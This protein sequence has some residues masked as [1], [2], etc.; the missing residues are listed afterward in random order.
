MKTVY[1][2]PS[3]QVRKIRTRLIRC[4]RELDTVI[5]RANFETIPGSDGKPYVLKPCPELQDIFDSS[6]NN[7]R[8]ALAIFDG[9]LK[10][11][12][13]KTDEKYFAKIGQSL[14]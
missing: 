14:G 8:G 13:D 12:H 4:I 7:I 9:S 2:N 1:D 6:L 10:L 5:N 11:L 3:K